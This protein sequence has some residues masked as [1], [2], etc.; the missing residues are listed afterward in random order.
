MRAYFEI[1]SETVQPGESKVVHLTLP[2]L[3]S[4]T[5]VSMPVHV[6]HGKKNG[7]VLFLSAAVHGDEINGV[8]I[9]RRILSLNS[10][11]H[12]K[13][14]LLA[15]PVVN[16]FGFD[17]HSRYL[18]DRRDLNRCFPGGGLGSLAGRL[19]N[20]F[21]SEVVC[22]SDF[23]IDLHTAAIHRDNFPQIRADLKADRMDVVSR[24]FASPVLLHSAPPENSL[25]YAAEKAGVPVMVYEAGEALRFDEVSIR[26]GVQGIL[27]VMRELGMLAKS[28]AKKIKPPVVLK[29]SNWIRA[30]KSGILRAQAALGDLVVKG[31]VLGIISDPAGKAEAVIEA[32]SEGIIIGR[33]NIPLVYEGEALFHIGRSQKTSLLEEHLGTMQDDGALMPPELVEEPAIV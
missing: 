11:K 31:D 32:T 25:R 10:I 6:V 30:S 29:S 13:G 4:E 24:A 5:E 2:G 26:I 15:V 16:V 8:E 27:N 7:P 18:P 22:R 21:M 9:I 17:N 12:L 3:H 19:A 28:R 1:N 23:G 33:S 20:I 14:T